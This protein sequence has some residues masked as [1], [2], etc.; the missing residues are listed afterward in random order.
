MNILH[1]S[2]YAN[3]VVTKAIENGDILQ[4]SEATTAAMALIHAEWEHGYPIDFN[5]QFAVVAHLFTPNRIAPYAWR[6][7]VN[8]LSGCWQWEGREYS[9]T[10][11]LK[12]LGLL[13]S[14][15]A[16]NVGRF[17]EKI[18]ATAYN[19]CFVVKVGFLSRI[20]KEFNLPT[21]NQ[22]IGGKKTLSREGIF[23]REQY[24]SWVK[25]VTKGY[26]DRDMYEEA[27]RSM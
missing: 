14:E 12:H 24:Q 5:K 7:V 9:V 16:E 18:I 26:I 8:G 3:K 25:S 1:W 11:A 13:T 21:L 2:D 19:S 10:V 23:L 20:V 6:M 15:E 17:T 27:V 22:S 4:N